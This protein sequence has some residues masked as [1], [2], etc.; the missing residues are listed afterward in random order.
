MTRVLDIHDNNNPIPDYLPGSAAPSVSSQEKSGG[1]QQCLFQEIQQ[2][3]KNTKT[4]LVH[5]VNTMRN[6][7]ILQL[8][9]QFVS[10]LDFME[11]AIISETSKILEQ[12]LMPD[13][14]NYCSG[15]GCGHFPPQ[16]MVL[17]II[18][19]GPTR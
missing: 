17:G 7:I 9:E 15:L 11:D 10:I 2:S 16:F 14:V 6:N 4:K 18:P 3:C 13:M 12:H 1:S 8:F 19:F 5:P